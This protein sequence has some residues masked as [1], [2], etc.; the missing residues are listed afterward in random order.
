MIVGTGTGATGWCSSI[1]RLQAPGMPLPT[2]T[3]SALAWFVREPWPSPST[4]ADLFAG[5]LDGGQV[6]L[7]VESDVLVAFGDGMEDDRLSLSW[8]QRVSVGV[9]DRT[10]RT[11][12]A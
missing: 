2:A 6:T 10:L 8:G 4:G 12:M 1:A 5:R 11:V 3:E 9:A 7:R